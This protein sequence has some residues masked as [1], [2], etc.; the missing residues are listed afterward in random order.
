MELGISTGGG[1]GAIIREYTAEVNLSKGDFVLLDDNG[2]ATKYSANLTMTNLDTTYGSSKIENKNYVVI[3]NGDGGQMSIGTKNADG[4]VSYS[5]NISTGITTTDCVRGAF[6]IG[7]TD[8]I[9]AVFNEQ[10]DTSYGTY[11]PVVY[12]IEISGG[13]PTFTNMTPTTWSG[14]FGSKMYDRAIN[15]HGILIT[16]KENLTTEANIA[17]SRYRYIISEDFYFCKFKSDGTSTTPTYKT[18]KICQYNVPNRTSS[19]NVYVDRQ[20]LSFDD[21][22]HFIYKEYNVGNIEGETMA[23]AIDCYIDVEYDEDD[24]LTVIPEIQEIKTFN[25]TKSLYQFYENHIDAEPTIWAIFNKLGTQT[26]YNHIFGVA[27]ADATTGSSVK[28]KMITPYQDFGIFE[29]LSIGAMYYIE[30][31]GT[32]GTSKNLRKLGIA[33]SDKEIITTADCWLFNQ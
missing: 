23:R 2:E 27:I 22:A 5:A 20:I 11:K 15:N 24:V 28:V 18:I 21:H 26:D 10:T 13:V 12:K 1:S 25:S 14:V 32:L 6:Q 30:D 19:Y 29:N 4:S 7:L 31:D 9:F 3:F 17:E 33:T 8:T 16:R